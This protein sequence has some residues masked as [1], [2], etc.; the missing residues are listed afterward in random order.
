VK[1]Y[2]RITEAARRLGVT[3]QYLPVLEWEGIIPLAR[4]D[5]YG[6]VYSGTDIALLKQTGVGNHARRLKRPDEVL[7]ER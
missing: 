3:A 2:V 1:R 4:R 7:G 5:F 6:R